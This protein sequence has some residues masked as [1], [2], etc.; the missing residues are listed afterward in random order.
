MYRPVLN[1]CGAQVVNCYM[2]LLLRETV[3]KPGSL[4]IANTFFYTKLLTG[5]PRGVKRWMRDVS[6][7]VYCSFVL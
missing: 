6:T 3:L 2:K 7:L 4:A 5:G 1:V